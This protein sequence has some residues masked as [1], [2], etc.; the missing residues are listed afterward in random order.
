MHE[1]DNQT[2]LQTR[3]VSDVDEY[4]K[5]LYGRL[6]Q[7]SYVFEDGNSKRWNILSHNIFSEGGATSSVIYSDAASGWA[8]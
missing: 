5:K 3:Y 6:I 4:H 7:F 8:G 1:F 2:F